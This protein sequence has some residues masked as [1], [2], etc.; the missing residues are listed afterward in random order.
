MT[1]DDVAEILR[2]DYK[3]V[4]RLVHKGELEVV[5]IG[6]VFRV[7]NQAFSEFMKKAK[8]KV[9]NSRRKSY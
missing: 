9:K 4:Y 2:V 6:R 7:T 3:T 5:K 8:E 1:L